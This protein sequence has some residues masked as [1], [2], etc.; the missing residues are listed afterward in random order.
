M[1]MQ[2]KSVGV[3]SALRAQTQWHTELNRRR[4]QFIYIY[5]KTEQQQ[6]RTF[7]CWSNIICGNDRLKCIAL[8]QTVCTKLACQDTLKL[9][10]PN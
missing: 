2:S 7:I 8:V 4:S 9:K 5:N 1:K 3:Q 6:Q 10:M